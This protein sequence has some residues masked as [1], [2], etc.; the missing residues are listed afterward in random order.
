MFS[1]LILYECSG[2]SAGFYL[3]KHK[4]CFGFFSFYVEQFRILGN[5]SGV[6]DEISQRGKI[7]SILYST[8][9]IKE[10]CFFQDIIAIKVKKEQ[11]LFPQNIRLSSTK[12]FCFILVHNAAAEWR[13]HLYRLPVP[14]VV[15]LQQSGKGLN[16]LLAFGVIRHMLSTYF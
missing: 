2:K 10:F 13:C 12:V 4:T 16:C 3:Q 14:N 8:E 6:I 7:Y 11:H 1:Q 15:I 9:K 5:G